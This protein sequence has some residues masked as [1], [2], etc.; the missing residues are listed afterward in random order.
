MHDYLLY[1]DES[2]KLVHVMKG[3]FE[4][5]PSSSS[6]LRQNYFELYLNLFIGLL[7]WNSLKLKTAAKLQLIFKA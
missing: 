3:G 4:P 2:L 6:R 5:P 1:R 7:Y